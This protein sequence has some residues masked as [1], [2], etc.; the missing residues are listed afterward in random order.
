MRAFQAFVRQAFHNT[1]I[2]RFSFWMQIVYAFITMYSA[3]WIWLTLHAQSPETVGIGVGEITTYAMVA[4]SLEMIFWPSRYGPQNYMAR[5]VRTG[6]IDTD[7][8]KPMDFQ[9]YMLGRN[10]GEII[11]RFFVLVLPTWVVGVMILDMQMPA[12]LLD[13]V[14][15]VISLSLGYLVLFSMNFL[16]GLLAMVAINIQYIMW[17]HNAMV[18][19]FAGQL[20]PLWLFPGALRT[21]AYILPFRCIYSIP[22]TFYIGNVP[23][24]RILSDLLLQVV[25]AAALTIIGRLLW[26]RVHFRLAV[27]GG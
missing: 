23:T 1:S 11:F 12:S 16:F 21:L 4:M 27:Q 5:Q 19:F 20:I 14:L 24:E 2:Y 13:G 26:R 25:W 15:F 3:K 10:L 18:R 17:A 6:A 9:A 8:L 7:L 22:L